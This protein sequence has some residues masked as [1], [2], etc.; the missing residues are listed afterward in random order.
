MTRTARSAAPLL[1]GLLLTAG[2]AQAQYK[3]V[4][5]DGSVT[6]TDR[7][8]ATS[9]AK[10]TPIGRNAIAAAAAVNPELA[11]PLELR[12]AMQRHPVTLYS[13]DA[14]VPCDNGRRLLQQR[15]VP[16]TER[17]I[18]TEED[19]AALER[20]LGGRSV[21]SLTIGNQPLRGFNDSDWM[22]YLD[23]AGYPKQS[24][25]P[26]T[27]QAQPPRPMVERAAAAPAAAPAP[28]P[29]DTSADPAP[30][31]PASGIRF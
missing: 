29:A 1:A 8:P 22:S 27:W 21:P 4:A 24:R 18:S 28:P 25:L 30:E 6:Y 9:N 23:A 15:G 2:L 13:G 17:R 7:P 11:L 10:I 31:A 19:V 16:F 14:C 5:P 26:R 3:L 20:L 12:T